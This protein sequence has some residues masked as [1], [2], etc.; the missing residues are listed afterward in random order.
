[1]YWNTKN[2]RLAAVSTYIANTHH[3]ARSGEADNGSECRPIHL[4]I[5]KHSMLR[6]ANSATLKQTKHP[7]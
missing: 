2:H 4:A 7:E 5:T 3:K 6:E 1:M